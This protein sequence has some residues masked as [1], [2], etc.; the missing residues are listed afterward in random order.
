MQLSGGEK[1]TISISTGT[2]LRVVA[3]LLFI[4]F[5]WM[6]S[7]IL[8]VVFIAFIFATLIEPLVNKFEAF[9]VPR[10][11]SIIG[12][13][14]AI[15]FFL[16][17]VVRLLIPPIVEQVSLIS[18][19]FPD[20]WE[21]ASSNFASL[22]EYT[23][24]RGLLNNIQS[25]LQDVQTNLTE[26]ASG[27]YS[28]IISLFRN[29]VNFFLTLV[30]TFYLVN[31]KDAL[32]KVLRAVSPKQHHPYLVDL[33][34][35]IQSKIGGWARGQLLLGLIIGIMTFL[36]LLF[37]MPKYALVLA[38]VAGITELIPYLGPIL[39]GIPAVFLAFTLPPFSIG[40]GLA[41]LILFMIIQWLENN[42]LVPR[43]MRR[44]VGLNPVVT[45]VA[46]LIGARVAGV[47][48]IIFAVPVTT[49]IS[50]IVKDYLNKSHLR[51]EE[52]YA[53]EL[54][55]SQKDSQVG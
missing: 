36:G 48:G 32:S 11:V 22:R 24:D 9:K 19:N 23:E 37:L 40:R 8:I 15:I 44:Q 51:S 49:A 25:G 35:R 55:Q 50:L 13:Y 26:A 45:I 17:L 42:L 2:I 34:N 47:V 39:G 53:V 7:D 5:L 3:I 1:V 46:M 33:T 28:F 14:V 31:Q 41:V 16:G 54:S 12:L 21:K 52:R 43:V 30:V 4:G 10:P 6:V 27:V 38:I 20:L 18:N 29:V